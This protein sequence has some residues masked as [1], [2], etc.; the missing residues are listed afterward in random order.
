[1]GRFLMMGLI[2]IIIAGL[3]NIFFQSSAAVRDLA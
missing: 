3:V 1:M 2:G